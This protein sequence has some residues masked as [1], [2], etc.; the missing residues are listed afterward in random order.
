MRKLASIQKIE[1]ISPIAGKDRIGLARVLGWDVIVTLADFHPGDKCVYV[2]IDSVLPDRP[3]FEFLKKRG[4]RIRT[5][6][7]AGVISQGICFPLS[8][9]P[10]KDWQIGDDV[11]EVL[12]IIH[13]EEYKEPVVKQTS[14]TSFLRKFMFKHFKR[15]AIII[16]GG[17]HKERAGFP[18]FIAKTDETRCQEIP[19]FF[20]KDKC[21]AM[22]DA[23]Y[24]VT[25]KVD[26]QSLTVFLRKKKFGRYDFGVCSR[27]LRLPKPDGSTWWT[28]AEKYKLKEVLHELLKGSRNREWVCL[29]GEVVGPTVQGNP[30]NLSDPDV[31]FFNLIYADYDYPDNP[32][33]NEK[34]DSVA[35]SEIVKPFGLKWVPILDKEFHL[36]DTVDEMV[37]YADGKSTLA[38][39]DREGV[40]VRNYR[41]DISFK[42][43]S[44][45]YLLKYEK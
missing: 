9:L 41:Y 31:Y 3:E 44:N 45:K 14:K 13:Y 29:Q 7:M 17:T 12:G 4:L 1:S 33:R 40:V 18:S 36:P 35:A 6:K 21:M 23:D 20:T 38:D 25:E 19:Q 8:I 22:L 2:E 27:N 32:A 11:T 34:V 10:E 37:K 39:T 15:L 24:I 16:Y 26:G 5:M 30:Y 42:A 43:V 28:V